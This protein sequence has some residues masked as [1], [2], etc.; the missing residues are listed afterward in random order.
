MSEVIVFFPSLILVTLFRR[1]KA[2]HPRTIS[3]V[4]EAIN[5]I[6]RERM[7]SKPVQS[8]PKTFSER[9]YFPWW[10]LIVAYVLSILVGG[11]CIA[12]IVIHGISYG[13]DKVRRW[14]ASIVIGFF[15][16]I[17]L[18]QPLK[19]LTLALLFYMCCRRKSHAEAFIEE[20]D[21]IE[22]F[23]VSTIDADK[24]FPVNFL[25]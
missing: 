10:C 4:T 24:K 6:K 9:F 14:L 19:V 18:T 12:F 16:S 11:V 3:P 23:T 17:F 21:P 22:D 1:T 8:S 7:M 20:E 25:R 13:D 2:R 5:R 15:S